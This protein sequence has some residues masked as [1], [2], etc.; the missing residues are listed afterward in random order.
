MYWE[1]LLTRV[2]RI[3]IRPDYWPVSMGRPSPKRAISACVVGKGVDSER[4]NRCYAAVPMRLSRG[5]WS[6]R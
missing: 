3:G 6:L 1:L 5:M 2:S 4:D